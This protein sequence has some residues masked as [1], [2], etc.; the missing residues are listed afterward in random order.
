MEATLMSINRGMDKDVVHISNGY[1]IS[2]HKQRKILGHLQRHGWTERVSYGVKLS[3][4]E[5]T[6]YH[7]LTGICV[8]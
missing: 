4:K 6:K 7:T 5:K 2:V 1:W 3:H 8:I